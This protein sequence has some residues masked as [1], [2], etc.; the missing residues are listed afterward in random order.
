MNITLKHLARRTRT[1]KDIFL[2]NLCFMITLVCDREDCVSSVAS[3][4]SYDVSQPVN[5]ETPFSP[6]KL[7]SLPRVWWHVMFQM[8]SKLFLL[9]W[10]TH[11]WDSFKQWQKSL[12]IKYYV[13]YAALLILHYNP[14]RNLLF[15]YYIYFT[16][17]GNRVTPEHK[18]VI[19]YRCRL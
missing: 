15:K 9:L 10:Q 12:Y 4:E 14:E 6:H 19:I 3:S 13:F 16:A 11:F 1:L 5:G 7:A 17:T 8:M 18:K 2:K